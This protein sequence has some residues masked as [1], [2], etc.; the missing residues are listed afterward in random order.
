[1]S[2]QH[3][4]NDLHQCTGA[5]SA[6]S[7]WFVLSFLSFISGAAMTSLC[8]CL[9]VCEMVQGRG[10]IATA[11]YT[12]AQEL[13]GTAA[14]VSPGSSNNGGSNLLQGSFYLKEVRQQFSLLR[15]HAASKIRNPYVQTQCHLQVCHLVT[16]QL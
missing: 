15:S 4:E 6:L 10:E 5:I 16:L 3:V 7:K 2:K 14:A 13:A 9:C 12:Q 8:V 11:S 1:M